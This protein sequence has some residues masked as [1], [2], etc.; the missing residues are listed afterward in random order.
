MYG[1]ARLYHCPAYG[2]WAGSRPRWNLQASPFV[3]YTAARR[4]PLN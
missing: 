1:C 3:P 2:D 4:G